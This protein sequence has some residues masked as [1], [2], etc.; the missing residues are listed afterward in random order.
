[1]PRSCQAVVVEPFTRGVV[2]LVRVEAALCGVVV[3][4][5]AEV[6]VAETREVCKLRVQRDVRSDVEPAR[7]VI[8]R[9]GRNARDDQ[10]RDGRLG[11]RRRRLQVGEKPLEETS[12]VAEFVIR[13]FT[14]FREN[15]VGKP[16]RGSRPLRSY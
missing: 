11:I 16:S 5:G 15:R 4:D 13:P 8:H 3:R 6:V 1:M 7:H 9:H 10:A 14:A 12:P 2:R